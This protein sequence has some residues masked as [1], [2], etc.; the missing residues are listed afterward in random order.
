[1]RELK[2]KNETIT[3][4]EY[5]IHSKSEELERAKCVIEDLEKTISNKLFE[6][7]KVQQSDRAAAKTKQDELKG[8]ITKLKE[9]K[10]TQDQR[11]RE[12]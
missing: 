4:K 10:T 12:L 2:N 5:E 8:K 1:M 9:E 3:K 11:I 7:E 6:W